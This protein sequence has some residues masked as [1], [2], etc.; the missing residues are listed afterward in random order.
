MPAPA[1]PILALGLGKRKAVARTY[2]GDPAAARFASLATG[3][4][5]A[6][7]AP[8]PGHRPRGDEPAT[9]VES[10][11]AERSRGRP[12]DSPRTSWPGEVRCGARTGLRAR[13]ARGLQEIV[14]PVMQSSVWLREANIHT[15][16]EKSGNNL[17]RLFGPSR[18]PLAW[19][20]RCYESGSPAG[21]R[22]R[23]R[24]PGRG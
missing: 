2:Q 14:L 22:R 7:A 23:I 8:P 3:R 21:P 17:F 10:H 5:P 18:T 20:R 24:G 9:A 15:G 11:P 4:A 19:R 16:I 12:L 6:A 13:P 1:G